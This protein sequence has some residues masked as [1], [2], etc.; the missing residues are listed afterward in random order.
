MAFHQKMPEFVRDR[1][2]GPPMA[3]AGIRED[4]TKTPNTVG[5]QHPFER[6]VSLKADIHD[7]E[8]PGNLYNRNCAVDA[9]DLSMQSLRNLLGRMEVCQIDAR[10]IQDLVAFRPGF[11]RGDGCFDDVTISL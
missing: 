10:Q 1:E 4:G 7:V 6:V 8:R 3:S 11:H 2:A 9:T 5:Q